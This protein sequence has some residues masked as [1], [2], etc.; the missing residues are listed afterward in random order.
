MVELRQLNSESGSGVVTTL[1]RD[2]TD[3]SRPVPQST[4]PRVC[5]IEGCTATVHGRGLC[6][7]HYRRWQKYGDPSVVLVRFSSSRRRPLA[8]RFWEKVQ[9][10]PD[11]WEWLGGCYH[12]GYGSFRVGDRNQRA[13]RVSYQLTYGDI[14]SGM[15]VM[16]RCDNPLCVRPDHLTVGTAGDNVRDAIHKGHWRNQ[17]GA[18]RMPGNAP[19][20]QGAGE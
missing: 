12:D 6:S 10:G 3:R 4:S 15:V 2:R 8:E 7:R 5:D 18:Q 17:H 14:P 9:R 19:A 16:H 1:P 20:Q 13:H 11:C